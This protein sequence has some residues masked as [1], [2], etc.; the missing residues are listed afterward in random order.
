MRFGAV[1]LQGFCKLPNIYNDAAIVETQCAILRAALSLAQS[2]A[3]AL[4]IQ[5]CHICPIRKGALRRAKSLHL[6]GIGVLT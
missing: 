5:T 2:T 6:L 3:N 4:Y 1:A